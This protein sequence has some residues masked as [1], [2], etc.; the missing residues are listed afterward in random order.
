MTVAGTNVP[1]AVVPTRNVTFPVVVTPLTASLNVAVGLTATATPV[2]LLAGVKLPAVG[3][4][5][6]SVV[7]DHVVVANALPAKSRIA[8]APPVNV[9]VY[10]APWTRFAVGFN[11]AT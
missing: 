7:N 8:A 2:A 5:L 6:S 1:V 4:V 10:V 9:A 11:V 3:G